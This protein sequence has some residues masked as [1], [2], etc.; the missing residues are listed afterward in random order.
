IGSDENDCF[1]QTAECSFD[2]C[3]IQFLYSLIEGGS[4][5]IVDR[6]DALDPLRFMKLLQKSSISLVELV[7]AVTKMLL[8]DKSLHKKKNNLRWMLTIAEQLPI[9]VAQEW[10]NFYP[11][12]NIL[13]AYGP[14]EASDDV[15]GYII[16]KDL[17]NIDIIPIGKPL[18]NLNMYILSDNLELC[19]VGVK[20]EI[21]ISGI[22][23]GK[24]YMNDVEKTSKKFLANPFAQQLNKDNHEVIYRTGDVGYWQGDGNIVFVGREDNMVKLRGA[25]I[26]TGE[27]EQALLSYDPIYEA[28]VTVSGTGAAKQLSAYYVSADEIGSS[29]LRPYLAERLPD[30]MIPAHFIHLDDM[31]RTLNGKV[32]RKKLP[33]P[34]ITIDNDFKAPSG[35][36]EKRMAA[37]WSDVLGLEKESIDVRKSF[38]ELGGNSLDMVRLVSKLRSEFNT[39]IQLEVF[40]NNPSIAELKSILLVGAVM[41][42]TTEDTTKVLI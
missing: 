42:K 41:N 14:A 25:R 16:P 36:L 29:F 22:G 33:Q 4:T 2:V 32:D 10:Y 21:C 39:N 23:V 6:E 26:E 31:P 8:A 13:N 7:P 3:V 5:H 35:E 37:L 18:A 15:T 11:N 28:V 9:E 38:F 20:G 19:P 40:F 17:S 1:A 30:Y 27:V 24:G 34:E 12:T